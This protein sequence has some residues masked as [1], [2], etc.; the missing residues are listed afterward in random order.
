MSTSRTGR[1]TFFA[2]LALLRLANLPTVWTNVLASAVLGAAPFRAAAWGLVAFSMTC[3]YLG[4]LVL[5]DYCD[6]DWDR[7]HRPERP[8]PSGAIGPGTAGALAAGLLLAGLGL[9]AAAPS[10]RGLPGGVLLLGMIAVYDRWHK[11][12]PAAP[13]L[14]AGCRVLACLVPALALGGGI[15][16][17]VL[18]LA[19]LQLGWVALLS[20]VARRS[21]Q[22]PALRPAV[23]WLLAGISL[24]D[25]AM[26]AALA[27]P[28]WILPG[29]GAALL[30]RAA[31]RWAPGD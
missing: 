17:A 23:P 3:F 9:L 12:N 27:S 25:G 18:L 19:G 15:G 31:Q 7:R 28:W 8:I 24:V 20:I 2:L 1:S 4:G 22:R 21:Q 6:R 16:V 30:T 11:G 5:N 14:M 29:L 13:L 10:W 26:L